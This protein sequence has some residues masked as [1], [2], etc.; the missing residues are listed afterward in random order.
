MTKKNYTKP[1]VKLVEWSCSK[2]VCQT[3]IT[4]SFTKCLN[5]TK[6]L[7]TT[8]FENRDD[9]NTIGDWNRVGSR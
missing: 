8:V 6:G 3:V 1:S 7:G 5:V 4:N 2:A 9:I